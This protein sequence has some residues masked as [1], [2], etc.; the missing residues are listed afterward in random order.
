MNHDTIFGAVLIA[1]LIPWAIWAARKPDLVDTDTPGGKRT[2]RIGL[3][4]A[5][6]FAALLVLWG[7]TRA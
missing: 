5:V 6:G 4:L 3:G 1:Y 7:I 2:S